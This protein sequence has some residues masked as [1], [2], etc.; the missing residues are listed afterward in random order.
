MKVLKNNQKLCPLTG[1]GRGY[2]R[3]LRQHFR[4][5]HPLSNVDLYLHNRQGNDLNLIKCSAKFGTKIC[6]K[7][8]KPSSMYL[9]LVKVHGLKTDSLEFRQLCTKT[10]AAKTFLLESVITKYQKM[11][12][13]DGVGS[14]NRIGQKNSKEYADIVRHYFAE[15]EANNF[16]KVKAM[17]TKKSHATAFK[18]CCVL[19]QFLEDFLII[20][21]YAKSKVFNADRWLL[22]IRSER[23][24]HALGKKAS[25][26]VRMERDRRIVN[27]YWKKLFRYVQSKKFKGALDI[28]DKNIITSAN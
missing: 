9:H 22:F 4:N 19:V 7:L 18:H 3:N 2:R 5:C 12:L 21:H 26:R 13:E 14:S 8:L 24:R 20:F 27:K 16:N 1:C 23:K 28:I 10:T 15:T 25:S 11:L 6:E 17:L